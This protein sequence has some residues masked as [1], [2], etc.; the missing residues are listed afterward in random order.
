MI[1]SHSLH[2]LLQIFDFKMCP[3]VNSTL[4]LSRS[5][6]LYEISQW[7][8]N[9]RRRS[10]VTEFLLLMFITVCHSSSIGNSMMKK[11]LEGLHLWHMVNDA[12]WHD[13][14]LLHCTVKSQCTALLNWQLEFRGGSS[15][16]F[17]S[18]TVPTYYHTSEYFYSQYPEVW[19]LIWNRA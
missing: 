16:G 9:S 13:T 11:L 8:Q 10:Y 7:L 3:A 17:S 18:C 19:K 15:S 4:I 5:N 14:H 12:H 2:H 6:L 1:F